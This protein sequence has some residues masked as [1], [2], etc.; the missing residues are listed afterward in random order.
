MDEI[1]GFCVLCMIFY[2]S[3]IFMYEQFGMA[4]GYEAFT[5]FLPVQPFFSC[6]F[7]FIC[8]ISCRLSRNNVKRGI[9]LLF[10]ALALS[11]VTIEILPELGFVN[12]EIYFGILHFLSIS[13]LIYSALEKVFDKIPPFFGC[14][15]CL[16]LFYVFRYWDDGII[17]LWGDISYAYP[18][19]LHEIEWLFPIGIKPY[20]FFSADYFPLIPYL[21]VFLFGSFIGVYVRA[22]HVPSF[23]YPVH[24]KPLYYLGTNA[25]WIYIIHLPVVFVILS[26]YEWIV[27]TLLA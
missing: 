17:A 23:A 8:G 11:F 10:L 19:S 27:N 24:V 25:L 6:A 3:F 7:M 13:I 12:T 20:G 16:F 18:D 1:R 5:F 14:A 15:V 21:F 22:G 9:K 4:I 26:F 2:H